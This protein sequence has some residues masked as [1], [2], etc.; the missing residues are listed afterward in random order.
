MELVK[1]TE[2]VERELAAGFEMG[3]FHRQWLRQNRPFARPLHKD[4]HRVGQTFSAQVVN[5]ANTADF[6]ARNTFTT[7]VSML[8]GDAAGAPTQAMINQ[9]CAIPANDAVAGRMYHLFFGGIYGT[10]ATPTIIFSPRWGSSVTIG[11]NIL[12]GVSQTF[13]TASGVAAMPFFGE[14]IFTIRTAP[15]GA[16]AGTGKG[17]GFVSLGVSAATSGMVTMGKTSAT[18]DTTGSGTA[19]CG[20]QIGI[21]WS[22]SSASNTIT[23]ENYLI[24]SLN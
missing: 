11:T 2:M 15:P 1:N 5:V 24:R 10:T 13:T 17:H 23:P 12:L 4:F 18:I 21:T 8:G 16:T 14:F 22:A 7:E 19:G 6:T 3:A 9:F 20:L